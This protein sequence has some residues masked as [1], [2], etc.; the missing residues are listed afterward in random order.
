MQ[1]AFYLKKSVFILALSLF[2]TTISGTTKS[3]CE[4]I[5]LSILEEQAIKHSPDLDKF[6]IETK[7]QQERLDDQQYDFYPSLRIQGNSE[8]SSDLSHGWGSVVS[9]GDI[10]QS[11]GTKYQNSVSVRANYVL[12]DFGARVQKELALKKSILASE[13]TQLAEKLRLRISVLNSYAAALTLS[14]QMDNLKKI[15]DYSQ[16]L[17][18]LTNRLRKAGKKGPIDSARVFTELKKRENELSLHEFE[19]YKR[20]EELSFYTGNPLSKDTLFTELPRPDL[21]DFLFNVEKHPSIERYTYELAS[22]QASTAASKGE[23]FPKVSLY[24]SYLLY[25]SNAKDMM[26]SYQDISESNF[27]VG[28]SL[29]V[30]ITDAFRNQHRV[31]Q[32][33][34]TEKRIR[35]EQR[36]LKEQL[37][38]EFNISQ[39]QYKYLLKDQKQKR[40]MVHILQNELDMLERLK[41]AKE[42]DAETAIRRSIVLLEQKA[43]LSKS[44]V[45][46]SHELLRLQYQMEATRHE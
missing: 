13:S 2:I 46:L 38:T 32:S 14:Q 5:S 20:L 21:S 10:V 16:E 28:V 6:S 26:K 45:E 19:L 8:Y 34:L 22:Q 25:G 30:P 42:I 11:T 17:N 4:N 7:L 39:R 24:S 41:K 18:N 12:Y 15:V 36:K 37:Q 23:Y 3:Y 1:T 31:S 43:A 40:T 33:E 9:V 35:A 27:T 29:V 44:V